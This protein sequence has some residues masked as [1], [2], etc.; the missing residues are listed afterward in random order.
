M[1]S[2]CDAVRAAEGKIRRGLSPLQTDLIHGDPKADTLRSS[3]GIARS[4]RWCNVAGLA[5]LALAAFTA[6]NADSHAAVLPP[7][8]RYALAAPAAR[9]TLETAAVDRQRELLADLGASKSQPLRY[10]VTHTIKNTALL[11]NRTQGGEW[12]DL[13]DGMAL[14]RIPVHAPNALSLDFSFRRFFLPPGAQLFIRNGR[15][16]LGPYTDA[17]NARSRQFSTP[18]IQ[19]DNAQIEVLLPQAMKRFLELDLATI[20]AG[21]RDVLAPTGISNPQ[22]GSGTCNV[23]T[24]CPQADLWRREVNAAAVLLFNGNVCSGEL[25][26]NT[27]SDH[28]PLLLTAKHCIDS[29]DSA[30]ALVVYWKY[31]SPTCRVVG[32]TDNALPISSDDAIAQTGGAQLLAVHADSDVTLLQLAAQPPAAANA[33]FNGWDIGTSAFADA[34]VIH[35]PEGD[36]KRI[37]F[38]AG[39]VTLDND[40]TVD[41]GNEGIYHW[42]VDH[43][44]QGTTENGSS[45][46]G[47][48]DLNHHLRGVLSA[49]AAA[50]S[51]PAGEDYY[52]R[53]DTA[54]QGGGTPS[55][56]LRDWLDP[57]SSGATQLD[58]AAS[59]SP[60]SV[61]LAIANADSA[62]TT[63]NAG[64][65]IVLSATATGGV[66]PYQYAFDV[67]GDGIADSTDPSQSTIPAVYPGA[68][69][70]NVSVAVTDS[71]GC[72]GSASRALIVQAPQLALAAV[73]VPAPAALCGAT[74]GSLNPGQ[75]WRNPIALINT[76]TTASQPGYA[77]FAQDSST[78]SQ[79]KL[80]LETPAIPVPALAPGQSTIVNLDYA[81][82]ATT[83][84][85]SPVSINLIGSVDARGF[86]SINSAV[87]NSSISANCQAVTTCAAVTTPIPLDSGSYYD[88]LRPGTGMTVANAGVGA[89]EP[90]LFALWFSGDVARQ[91]TWYQ[92][93]S[94]LHANQVNGSLYRSSQPAAAM[95]WPATTNAVGTAQITLV[96]TDKFVFSWTLNGISGGALYTALT[97]LPSSIRIWYNPTESGWGV[98]DQLVQTDAASSAPL[99]ASIVYVFDPLGNPRWLQAAKSAYVLGDVEQAVSP[100]PACPGCVW[101]DATAGQQAAGNITYSGA[102]GATLISTNLVFPSAISGGWT[103]NQFPLTSLYAFP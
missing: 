58:G 8:A 57:T 20:H 54:W 93:Q 62:A 95:M 50:C 26:N 76:G 103:R 61:T 4:S 71:T 47:L 33:Y 52:G 89:S 13:P 81:I 49:G 1:S 3:L 28:A 18:L 80:T 46:S 90:I 16:M 40:A 91:P 39:T 69:A 85:G 65:K 37:S 19:G 32:S 87:I 102:P 67:D 84:C 78:L 96:D 100:R 27:R 6:G 43:Y 94:L 99:L 98:Y 86:G 9:Y 24:L 14:W 11:A 21:Y 10:A 45:G 36:A 64:D 23:D 56:R 66:A 35:H 79:A 73:P 22:L 25:V 44:S 70:G 42:R 41:D 30:S 74:G 55:T 34:I 77:I 72:T 63:I 60:P 7:S 51:D 38:A 92:V 97:S 75:R 88:T 12:R 48:L 83:A 53:L 68:Y 82:D 29:Q 15:Q 17:D 59:C 31:E 2:N 101:L 5:A